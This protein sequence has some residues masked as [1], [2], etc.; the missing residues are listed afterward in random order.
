MHPFGIWLSNW[1][2]FLDCNLCSALSLC[3]LLFTGQWLLVKSLA[4]A[5]NLESINICIST[6]LYLI[7][8]VRNL[9]AFTEGFIQQ[10]CNIALI[11]W[12]NP[13][14]VFVPYIRLFGSYYSQFL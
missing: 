11:V 6:A 10:K 2:F 7:E 8:C 1:L 4:T 14:S 5:I 3:L 9:I 13:N 12:P